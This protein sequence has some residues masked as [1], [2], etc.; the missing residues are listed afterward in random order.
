MVCGGP[1]G[2]Y[3]VSIKFNEDHIPDSP[4]AVLVASR[5][6]DAGRLAVGSLQEAGLKVGQEA[7]FTVNGARGPVD[8]HIHPPSGALEACSTT[9]LDH[10]QHAIRF[11]PRENGVHSIDVRCHGNHVPGSPFKIRVGEP[12]QAGDPGMVSA[13]GPGLE[14]GATGAEAEFLVNTCNAGSGSLALT[15]DGPSKVKMDCQEGPEGYKVAYTPMAPGNYLISIKYGGPQHI[16]GSPFKAK[17]SGP[18]LSGGLG[19][20]ETSSVVVETGGAFG[21]SPRFSSD[22]S[23]AVPRGPGLAEAFV[24]QKNQFTVD[25]SRAGSDMLLVGVHGPRSPC[26][27]VSVKHLGARLYSVSYT[28]KERGGCLL[29]VKWGDHHVPGSP[30]RFTVS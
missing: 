30:F 1:S 8:A 17:V 3:E 14:G 11:V 5:S 24:G 18:R 20:H 10:D 25:C 23:R 26:E 4:F 19:L 16:V 2:D 6:G 15:I 29:I 27:E 7:S 12:G 9:E 21:T 13:S 28:V 22:A